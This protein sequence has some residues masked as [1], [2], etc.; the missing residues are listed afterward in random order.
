M[1][2]YHIRIT[3]QSTPLNEEVRL[4]MTRQQ[5]ESRYLL[6]YRRG[7]PLAINGKTI[8]TGDIERIKIT[9]TE[10]DS[11]QLRP[12]AEQQE[13]SQGHRVELVPS[14]GALIAEQGEDITNELITGPPGTGANP[15]RHAVQE[16]APAPNAREIFVVHGRNIAMRDELFEFLR[17]IDLHPLEWSEAVQATGHPSPYIGEILDAAFSRAQAIVVLFTP[18]DEVRLKEEFRTV[19][20]PAYESE[21]TGQARP[22]VLF[23]SG[24]AMGRSENRTVLVEIGELKPF[25]D[26]QGRHV[27]RLNNTSERRQELAQRLQSAGCPVNL[28]GT[29]WHSAGEFEA[30]IMANSPAVEMVPPPGS[31]DEEEFADLSSAAS[32]A[33]E[34][35]SKLM[36]PSIESSLFD[37][38]NIAISLTVLANRMKVL[39]MNELEGR[40]RAN[41]DM[42]VKLYR[43]SAM[44]AN[45]E[46]LVSTGDYASALQTFATYEPSTDD[47]GL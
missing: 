19:G 40:L 32:L 5:L 21:L 13:R 10:Q 33:R 24:M 34:Q 28:D 6:P 7:L 47:Q 17:S 22:N 35:I 45:F 39:G 18:D 9:E 11:D 42:P 26:V 16:V 36:S 46:V 29:D 8:V 20:D 38:G 27:I 14:I 37:S 1:P 25:S 30:T 23:E 3:Q 41:G 2:Y 15:E 44:L 43:I 4:D 12:L 31:V